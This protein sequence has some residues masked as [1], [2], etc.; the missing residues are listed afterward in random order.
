MAKQ[1][2]DSLV[3]NQKDY[4]ARLNELERHFKE[5][6]EEKD[7]RIHDLEEQVRDLMVYIDAQ[8]TVEG[9]PEMKEGTVLSVRDGSSHSVSSSSRANRHKGKGKRRET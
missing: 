9:S 3:R 1:L 2:N 8:N 4:Q 5:A 7:G 6:S